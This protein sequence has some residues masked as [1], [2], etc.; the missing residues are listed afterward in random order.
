MKTML[1]T[2]GLVL[3]GTTAE[4]QT[5]TLWGDHAA[6]TEIP[7]MAQFLDTS[8]GKAAW[9]QRLD[10]EIKRGRCGIAAQGTVVAVERQVGMFSCIRP[11]DFKADVCRWT[12]LHPNGRP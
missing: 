7:I 5:I 6:C 1:L 2:L 8:I 10:R 4:A 12:V 11:L 9:E 3:A